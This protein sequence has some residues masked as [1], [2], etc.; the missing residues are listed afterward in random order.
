MFYSDA[1][2]DQFVANILGFKK[3]GVYI[4]IG[5][6]HS[7]ISNNTFFFDSL[8]WRGI[9]IE[10]NSE[11]NESYSSRNNCTFLN[12]DAV[13]VNY[14]KIFID[15]NF[16]KS[17]DYL[18]LDIDTLSLHVLSKL[19][20]D[21]WRFKVITIE[22]DSYLYGDEYRKKQRDILES[23]GYF[24]VCSDVYVQQ[25]GFDRPNSSFEDWW[26]DPKEFDSNLI[27]KIKSEFSYP[28]EIISKFSI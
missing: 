3:N 1:R 4:D 24:L 5:S 18:S 14:N 2:Q 21:E 27:S 28:S 23:E 17:I 22:H 8:N 9:C 15:N 26:I 11:F 20:L 19:P 13:E 25:P 16:P 7:I 12:T 10:I 6:C